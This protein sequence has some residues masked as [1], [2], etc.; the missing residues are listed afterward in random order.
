MDVKSDAA[1]TKRDDTRAWR[2]IDWVAAER[3]VRQ[4]QAR[5]VKATEKGKFPP[6]LRE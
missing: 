2:E 3:K 4:L 6:N 1:P 5:I